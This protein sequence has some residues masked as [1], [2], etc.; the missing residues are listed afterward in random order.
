M[1]SYRSFP[2][3]GPF[4]EVYLLAGRLEEASAHAAEALA[5]ARTHKEQGSEAWTLRLLGD[6]ATHGE[7]PQTEPAE[8][9]YHQ[10]LALAGEL[11][12][13]PLQAHCHLGLGRLYGQT[14]RAEQARVALATAIDL[15]RAMDMTFWLPQAEAALAQVEEQ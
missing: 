2:P 6:I 5:L 12:V 10:A 7:P 14:D 13:R 1:A 15:Y 9:Y 3:V 11:G 4:S 8:A